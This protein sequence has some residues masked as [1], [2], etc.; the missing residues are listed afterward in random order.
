MGK[1]DGKAA[2]AG[3]SFRGLNL[4]I[5]HRNGTIENKIISQTRHRRRL[6]ARHR[7]R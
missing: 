5:V 7:Q 3:N 4:K 6:P 1:I 2:K